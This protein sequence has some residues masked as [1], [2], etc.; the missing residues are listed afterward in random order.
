MVEFIEF[1]GKKF[2]FIYNYYALSR[3]RSHGE[4]LDETLYPEYFVFYCIE[5]GCFEMDIPFTIK[6]GDEEVEFTPKDAAFLIGKVGLDYIFKLKDKFEN[7]A[8][9]GEKKM[10]E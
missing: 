10:K 1:K 7:A 8:K 4:N 6:K 3:L 5:A 9:E 2:P